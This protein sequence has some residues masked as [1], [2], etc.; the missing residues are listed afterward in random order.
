MKRIILN[1]LFFIL[2]LSSFAWGE[3]G[4]RMIALIAYDLL[5]PE[6]KQ[7]VLQD[8]KH[9]E[10][11]QTHFV[12]LMTTSI[13]STDQE[14]KNKWLFSHIAQ[15]PDYIKHAP[16]FP[17]NRKFKDWH[18]INEPLYLTPAD[19]TYFNNRPPTNLTRY[20]EGMIVKDKWNVSQAYEYNL[21]ILETDTTKKHRAEALCWLFHLLGDI[22]QPLHSA[23]L[24]S[25]PLFKTGDAG[26]NLIK[27]ERVPKENMHSYWD[28]VVEPRHES[29]TN[30]FDEILVA[31]GVYLSGSYEEA[32]KEA[33][34]HLAFETWIGESRNLAL[35]SIYIQPVRT[36]L[37][38]AHEQP[39]PIFDAPLTVSIGIAEA[40]AFKAHA[41]EVAHI[42][43]AEAG[44]RLAKLLE[45]LYAN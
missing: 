45:M 5:T 42:R 39:P 37:I 6:T 24:F 23:A 36:A 34:T 30:R 25:N 15:W 2:P 9:H 35:S 14:K 8:L 33:A 28:N 26:G 3:E 22:H 41:E 44:F 18:Y 38:A 32:G 19:E 1:T 21:H 40:D 13:S 12:N 10:F 27:V 7:K 4:H 31:Y 43:I 20:S 16:G 17:N 29:G 11:Y